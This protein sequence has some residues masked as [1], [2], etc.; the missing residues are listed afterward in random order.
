[1]TRSPASA[2]PSAARALLLSTHPGPAAA[3]SLISVVLAVGIGLDAGRVVLVGLAIVFNQASIGLSNDWIDVDRDRAVGR[4]DKPVALGHVSVRAARAASIVTATLA[5]ALTVPLGAGT[6]AAHLVFLA[7][8]WL[9]NAWLK[10]T[11]VSVVPYV[12]GF[13]ALPSIVTL[14]RDQPVPAAL[15]AT[16]LGAL[17]GVAAHFANVL[18]DLDDDAAT[19]IRGLP[20]A[21][22]RRRS[23]AVICVA[24]ALGAVL[25]F[26]GPGG[27]PTLLQWAGLVV[28]LL[29]A[30]AIA[31]Q[32]VRPPSRVVFR[33]I[34]AAAVIDVVL[35]V[36]A[37]ERLLG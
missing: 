2:R 1:V 4:T 6:V 29:L 23:G 26:Q 21:L 3:I 16:A 19:G 28:S 12:T 34:I 10:R 11:L 24:L 32:L 36:G 14:A 15:W 17:L 8:G 9:Y 37:G 35:L 25:A 18:P 30:V 22:G 27:E 5:V 33:L 7:S 31:V 20:H 13:G